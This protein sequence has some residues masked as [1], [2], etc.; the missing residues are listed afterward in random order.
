M[1]NKLDILQPFLDDEH[2]G[3]YFLCEELLKVTNAV[4]EW[5]VVT[6]PFSKDTKVVDHE[7]HVAEFPTHMPDDAVLRV[8]SVEGATVY[9]KP[10]F[11]HTV[12]RRAD[13]A[14]RK[15][16]L[17]CI[18]TWTTPFIVLSVIVLCVALVFVLKNKSWTRTHTI[19]LGLI[20][21]CFVTEVIYFFSVLR[22]YEAVGDWELLEAIFLRAFSR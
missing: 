5:Q 2:L 19:G 21:T 4:T 17:K 12:L 1:Q 10:V 9:M 15:S 3:K 8:K 14:A 20:V 7:A 18:I 11:E 13:E 22:P 16:N 6:A